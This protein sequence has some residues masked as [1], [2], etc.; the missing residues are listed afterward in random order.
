MLLPLRSA[1][2]RNPCSLGWS[3]KSSDKVSLRVR[4]DLNEG[5]SIYKVHGEIHSHLHL[6]ISSF[7]GESLSLI[8]P[9]FL[10]LIILLLKFKRSLWT[11]SLFLW[12]FYA[13]SRTG[14]P[15]GYTL[16]LFSDVLDFSQNWGPLSIEVKGWH[17]G[18]VR[19]R[20]PHSLFP[21]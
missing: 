10:N 16:S 1:N 19:R 15:V 20:S 2:H 7:N 17:T 5:N 8:F 9:A 6:T 11:F 3:P 12:C 13:C 21:D 14:D 4:W 18:G